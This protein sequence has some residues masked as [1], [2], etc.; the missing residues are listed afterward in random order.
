MD[1]VH[2]I[3]RLRPW[4]KPFLAPRLPEIKKL[5]AVEKL[6]AELLNAMVKERLE[7]EKTDPNWQKPDDMMQWLLNHSSASVSAEEIA[8]TQLGLIFAAIHTTTLTA[9]N[10]VYTLAVTP[11]C[12]EPMREEVR[13]AMHENG[14]QLTSKALQ[15]LLKLDSYMKECIRYHALGVGES[16][17]LSVYPSPWRKPQTNLRQPVSFMRRVLKGITL[18]N[19]QC[20]YLQHTA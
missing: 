12:M 5:R 3:K 17:P 16:I 14:G 8:T 10:I 9:T 11:E 4:Q 18:S 2:A 1:A 6:A 13:N 20:T 15:Q 7:A 19:G